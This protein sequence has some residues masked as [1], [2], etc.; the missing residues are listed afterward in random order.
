MSKK[1]DWLTV[2]SLKDFVSFFT[3]DELAEVSMSCKKFRSKLNT[4]IF[5]SFN[6]NSF[7]DTKIYQSYTIN[8]DLYMIIKANQNVESFHPRGPHNTANEK[9]AESKEQFQSDLSSFPCQ[10]NRLDIYFTNNYHYLLENTTNVFTMLT[11]IIIS[12][13][14][15]KSQTFQYLLDNI[16]KLESLM[17]SDSFLYETPYSHP[18]HIRWPA[19]LKKLILYNNAAAS[20]DNSNNSNLSVSTIKGH[21]ITFRVNL[22][23]RYLPNLKFFH[24][25]TKFDPNTEEIIEFLILN[26]QIVNLKIGGHYYDTQ[27]LAAI[28]SISDLNRLYLNS[29]YYDMN[30]NEHMDNSLLSNVSCLIITWEYI[31]I[32]NEKLIS[33]FS[34]LSKLVIKLNSEEFGNIRSLITK[35]RTVKDISLKLKVHSSDLKEFNFPESL[36]LKVVE[37]NFNISN[38]FESIKWNADACP[39][40]KLIELTNSRQESFDESKLKSELDTDWKAIYFPYK[41]SYYRINQ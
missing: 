22:S 13:S 25:V 27:L 35:F 21:I 33:M 30:L 39:N 5:K 34:N 15:I 41:I 8:E 28:K 1:S 40:L 7:V 2:L 20:Y 12:S 32:N 9:I 31:G 23:P 37:F 17:L 18:A 38:R 3:S 10:P 11:S 19:S 14:K 16:Q 29:S 6:F 4:T 36:N 24:F 26:P